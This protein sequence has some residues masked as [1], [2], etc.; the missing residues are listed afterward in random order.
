MSTSLTA[1]D[2]EGGRHAAAMDS[3]DEDVPEL[4]EPGQSEAGDDE[5]SRGAGENVSANTA[6]DDDDARTIR[7]EEADRQAD[8]TESVESQPEAGTSLT[9][10][11]PIENG[12]GARSR[13]RALLQEQTLEQNDSASEDGSALGLPQRPGSPGGDSVVSVP[14][15]VAS[16]RHSIVSSLGGS[17]VFPSSGSLSRFGLRGASPSFR[18]FD[19]RFQS[20]IASPSSGLASPSVRPSSPALLALSNASHQRSSSL[21]S[22]FPYGDPSSSAAAS[23]IGGSTESATP[24]WEVVRWTKLVKLS[25]QAFSES[26]KRN[27]GSPT[28]MAISAAIVLGTTK[29]ILLV[30][31]Y[32]QNLKMIIGPGTKGK[33]VEERSREK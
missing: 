19:Q 8:G 1:R 31:D 29:G 10:P 17:S 25:G 27:F 5:T 7:G 4:S 18:P 14:G 21:N 33:V 26:A 24:P 6:D 32:N 15:S 16:N 13:Y 20:R 12:S 2:D 11:V 22:Q 28:C 23:V 30:F 9:T 3:T